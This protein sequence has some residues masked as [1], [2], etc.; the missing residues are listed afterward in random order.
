MNTEIKPG[1]WVK[2]NPSSSEVYQ[3]AEIKMFPHG[4][5]VGIFDEPPS[6][7]I[8]Y[9][10]PKS[11]TLVKEAF[12][13]RSL[14]DVRG[15]SAPFMMGVDTKSKPGKWIVHFLRFDTQEFDDNG[16][17]DDLNFKTLHADNDPRFALLDHCH[18]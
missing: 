13:I 11:L 17:I 7:H 15:L 6:E 1:D 5:M 10:N 4:P 16:S 8:D 12:N 3:V 18:Q 9:W 14:K 2:T